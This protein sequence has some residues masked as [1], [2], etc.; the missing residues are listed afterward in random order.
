MAHGPPVFIL[1]LV[2]KVRPATSIRSPTT[3]KL[4]SLLS[5]STTK[6]SQTV[7]TTSETPTG[8]KSTRDIRYLTMIKIEKHIFQEKKTL[9]FFL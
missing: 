7:S 3:G 1:K 2:K 5:L 8:I 6:P 9:V 4:S